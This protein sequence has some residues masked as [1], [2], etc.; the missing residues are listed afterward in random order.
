[1]PPCG[2]LEKEP[3]TEGIAS[4]KALGWE[5][6]LKGGVNDWS[7]VKRRLQWSMRKMVAAWAMAMGVEKDDGLSHC[8]QEERMGL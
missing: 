1:M 8:L 3:Q 5:R 2:D 6:D 4:E 7:P